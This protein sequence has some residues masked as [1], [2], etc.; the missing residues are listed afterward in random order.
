MAD[1]IALNFDRIAPEILKE[2]NISNTDSNSSVAKKVTDQYENIVLEREQQERLDT[3]TND[4]FEIRSIL[5]S[6]N[7]SESDIDTA[8]SRYKNLM[9]KENLAFLYSIDRKWSND[10]ISINSHIH[11]YEVSKELVTHEY[12][13]EQLHVLAKYS[14]DISLKY[15]R[16]GM[17]GYMEFYK[18]T[19][20]ILNDYGSYIGDIIDDGKKNAIKGT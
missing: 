17:S 8:L 12:Y 4:L 7:S 9:T 10:A 19:T 16:E 1:N 14:H 13:E 3:I 18:E 2:N 20:K 6:G 11:E 15:H 5:Y